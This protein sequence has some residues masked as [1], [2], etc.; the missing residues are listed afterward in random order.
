MRTKLLNLSAI[1]AALFLSGVPQTC[2]ACGHVCRVRRVVVVRKA[3][4]EVKEVLAVQFI[5]VP[6]YSIGYAPYPV[7]TPV[8]APGPG[9]LP[10][11]PA[12][13]PAAAPGAAAPPTS[14][15]AAAPAVAQPPAAVLA[16]FAAKC[17]SCHDAAA[18]A[19]KG[20]RFTLL[21]AGQLAPLTDR[22]AMKVATLSYS[23]KMPKSGEKLTDEEV[24][25][26]MQ[27][28]EGLK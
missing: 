23:G 17:A 11:P 19:E 16:I 4:V 10:P 22:Q 14:A 24:A 12:Q 13:R 20:G 5:P 18:A 28:V 21:S 15:P 9:P 25:S 7:P 26:I 27:Y 1:C 2:L 6:A 8:P 3:V